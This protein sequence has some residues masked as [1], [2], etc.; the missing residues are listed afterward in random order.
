MTVNQMAKLYHKYSVATMYILGFI[1][2]NNLYAIK[3]TW[4]Q[5]KTYFK[6]DHMSSSRGGWA[7]IRIRLTAEQREILMASA[8]LLGSKEML[9]EDTE[10]NRGDNLERIL[11]EKIT[12][13][14][15]KKNNDPFWKAGD[16][17]TDTDRFQVKLDTAELTN[18]KTISNLVA[19]LG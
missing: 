17:D 7:K 6:L 8:E 18:E 5:I 12:H 19:T 10:H 13:K 11:Y 16:I 14:K 2:G 9:L 4:E 1:V 15:W 3:I